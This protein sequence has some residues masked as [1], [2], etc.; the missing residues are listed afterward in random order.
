M[1]THRG[2]ERGGSGEYH[3]HTGDSATPAGDD[4]REESLFKCKTKAG[5]LLQ[6]KLQRKNGERGR[7]NRAPTGTYDW[8]DIREKRPGSA[9]FAPAAQ[10]KE[11]RGKNAKKWVLLHCAPRAKRGEW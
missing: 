10:H 1:Q 9:A 7:T 2:E 11:G 3:H 5:L 6:C 8:R 4:E